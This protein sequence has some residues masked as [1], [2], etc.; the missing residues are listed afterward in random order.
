MAKFEQRL[1][2]LEEIAQGLKDEDKDITQALK[3]FEEG[4]SL[5]KSLEKEIDQMERRVE[6]LLNPEENA[7]TGKE[8]NFE[9]FPDL[10][11][12]EG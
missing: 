10:E 12:G 7:A 11:E 3:E 5:A 2:R 4:I 9:L 6:I 1:A 8:P